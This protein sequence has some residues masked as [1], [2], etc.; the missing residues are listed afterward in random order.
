MSP[1][2]EPVPRTLRPLNALS[3]FLER[4]ENA[5]RQ[6]FLD[7]QPTYLNPKPK[8]KKHALVN[9]QAFSD[10]G[11]RRGKLREIRGTVPCT[12]TPR[13]RECFGWTK[14]SGQE[15]WDLGP[16]NRPPSDTLDGLHREIS[17]D[18]EYYAIVYEFIPENPPALNRDV[19]QSQL[20]FYCSQWVMIEGWKLWQDFTAERLYTIFS[21]VV[22]AEWN[23]RSELHATPT[24]WDGQVF[25]EDGLEHTVLTTHI[26]PPVNAALQHGIRYTQ[27]DKTTGINL[28]RAGRTYYEPGGDRRFKP[29]WALCSNNHAS[30]LEDGS[31]RYHSLMPGDSKLSNKWHST[32]YQPGANHAYWRDPVHQIAQYCI[33]A[34]SR[35]GFIITDSELVAI[36]IRT[37]PTGEG[38]AADRSRRQQPQH[39]HHASTSTDVSRL[40]TSMRNASI[41]DSSSSWKPSGPTVDN[42]PVEYR[43]IPW[44]SHGRGKSHLTVR[45]ALF[46]LAWMAGVGRNELQ[47]SYPSLDSSWFSLD[48]S[49]LHN[50]T[51][52]VS[53]KAAKRMEYSDPSGERGPRWETTEGGDDGESFQVLT[54]ES[55]LT[56]EVTEHAGRNHYYY[57]DEGEPVVITSEIP[58]YDNSGQQYGYFRGADMES[59]NPTTALREFGQ[60]EEEEAPEMNGV[61]RRG[62]FN[63]DSCFSALSSRF[64]KPSDFRLREYLG[65]GEDGF[66]FKAQIDGQNPVA[67]KIFLHNRKPEPI[68]GVGRYWAFERECLNCALLE[69]ID[70]SL[71]RARTTKRPI[72]LFPKPKTR[73]QALRNLFAFSDEAGEKGSPPDH[74]EP[75]APDVRVNDCFGWTEL[76]GSTINAALSKARVPMD[77][78]NGERYFAIVYAFVPKGRLEG[79]AILSQLDFFHIAGFYSVPFNLTNW[80][81][82]G[83]LVDFSDIVSPF[84]DRYDWDEHSACVRR[85][86]NPTSL[87]SVVGVELPVT[88]GPR[89]IEDSDLQRHAADEER[90]QEASS[91]LGVECLPYKHT[92]ALKSPSPSATTGTLP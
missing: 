49:C 5:K 18:E 38:L 28:S 44:D 36:R 20:D 51:G 75:F 58:I 85:L 86:T 15:L 19:I 55:V 77:I 90:M 78:D 63:H 61:E 62:G 79:G 34:N 4:C 26:L 47:H 24:S 33:T 32:F 29:D 80:L 9:L 41:A 7:P 31:Y 73:M 56:L 42:Y 14:V 48:G 8:T 52:L 76:S 88:V 74:F 40:S 64:L 84:A 10:E 54:L 69:M 17:P 92:E 59:W 57:V 6:P 45:L 1:S 46:Y 53:K 87:P 89:A 50:T 91:G 30:T 37:E 83:V 25:D 16:K 66:V 67:V 39:S 13:L 23:V 35:Y 3:P 27:L 68:Y 72:Y 81:G 70:A 65:Q 21:D 43:A 60:V 12:S 82:T 71:H 11:R 2:T 22:E